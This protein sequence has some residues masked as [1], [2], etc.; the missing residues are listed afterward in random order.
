MVKLID[1][2][3][4][5]YTPETEMLDCDINLKPN[6]FRKF[7]VIYNVAIPKEKNVAYR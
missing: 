4:A 5:A 2:S 1:S 3:K 7:L 6:G